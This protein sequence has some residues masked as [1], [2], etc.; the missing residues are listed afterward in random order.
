MEELGGELDARTIEAP[1]AGARRASRSSCAPR[2]RIGTRRRE[3]QNWSDRN[4]PAFA[5]PAIRSIRPDER[6]DIEPQLHTQRERIEQ[7]ARPVGGPELSDA[8]RTALTAAPRSSRTAPATGRP[9]GSRAATRTSDAG[10]GS[11]SRGSRQH[12]DAADAPCESSAGARGGR[13]RGPGSSRRLSGSITPRSPSVTAFSSV[14]KSLCRSV[15]HRRHTSR[16]AANSEP[17]RPTTLL[18]RLSSRLSHIS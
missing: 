18:T 2:A 5:V 15:A 6:R 9:C 8:T 10:T 7:R 11:A 17:L 3:S 12:G 1:P 16:R 13:R 4:T 14:L